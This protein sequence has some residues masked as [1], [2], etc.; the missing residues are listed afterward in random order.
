MSKW[1]KLRNPFAEKV[2]YVNPSYKTSLETSISSASGK[3]KDTLES[4]RDIPSAYWLD[5]K[6]KIK[7]GSTNTMEGILE[8]AANKPVPELVL[9]IVYDLPNRDCHAKAS[10]GEICCSYKSDGRCD[11]TD[12]SDKF[13]SAGLKEYEEEY[14]DQIAEVLRKYS[15]RVPV[16]LVI[17]PDSL[18]N[19]STN[20]GDP[21]CGNSATKSAYEEGVSYAVKALATADPY[22]AIYLD[23]GHGGW[24]GWKDN[25]KDFVK[26]IKGLKVSSHIRGFA[27]N[28]AGY[29][30]VGEICD[31]YDFCLGGNNNDHPCCADPCDLIGQWNPSNNELNYAL[32]LRK[33]MS[34]GIQGF[35]PHMIIDTGRNGAAGMRSECKNWCNIRGAGVG[36]VATIATANPEVVDAYFWLKTPGESDGCTQVLPD[37]S[38]C[39]RFDTDCASVDSIGSRN[40][41]PRAPEAGQWF[42]F[43][44]KQLAE[45][46]QLG[47][48]S[49]T[50][51]PGS[52]S[53]STTSSSTAPASTTLVTSTGSMLVG[54]PFAEKVFYVNPSYKTSLETSIGSASGKIK[55]TLESMRDIPS[56]Y[57]LDNKGKIKG[58]STNTMEGILEDAANK[59]VPE[60]VLFIVYD[61]PNR[62]CHAKASNGEICCSYKSDGRCDYTD[63]SDKFCS[64]GLKEYEEEY[65]DQ[66]AE[67]LRKYSGRVPVVLVIEPDSLPNLSTNQGDP[68]CGNSATKSAYEEGVSYAVKALATADPYAAI[69]LDAGHGGWLGWKDNMKDFVKTIKGLKVSS[70]IRGFAS[71]V[72]GYQHVGEICDTYDFCL[73]GNNNDHPCCA[74]PCDLIGQWNPSNNELNY[75][76]HLRKAMSEGIQGFMPHMII[77]TGRNGAAGMRSECKN[78]CNIRGAGVGHVATIA[79]ANPEVVD[80]YFWLKTPGESDGCTQ[81]LPDGSSCPRFDTDCASVDS[82][83]SRNDE[84]RAPEAGQWFD[85]QIKQLAENAQLGMTSETT[86]PGSTSLSTTSSSTAPASTTLVTSTGSM[87]VGNPFAE[88]VFYVNPSY[89]TSLETSIGSASGKIKDTLESMRDIP[90]AYWLDNKGKIKGGSTNTMEGILEDAA[91]K[92]VPELVLF[93]V[94]DLPNRDCHAKASN[95]EICCSYKSDGRCDYTD[96]SDKFC[97]AGLKEYEEEYI[98]QIAEVLRK[99]SGRVPVV[100]VIEPDSLPNLSTNQ[101]DPR[102]GNSATKSAYEEGVSY[103]V[104][105]LATADP[106]A[107]IYLDAGHGGWLGWKDN[108]KDF[109][110]TIKGLK[111]SSHIRGFASNVAGYQH[112]GEICDT[113]DFCLG[114]NNNDHPCCADPC[115]LIG[116][117][118]PSNNELNYALHLRK[119]MSEGI[120]G[121]MPHMI[122]DTGRN[123]AAGMRSECKNWCNIRGAGVGHVATIAT[124]NP[125]VVDAYFWLKTPGESDGCTQVLPDGS[126]CPRFDTDCASVDSIGSRNDEP[127]AP[128]AGQWFDFQIKQ[129]AE[130]ARLQ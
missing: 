36:H 94:Y 105:A 18:P 116:Q 121:F 52:T 40:D 91:N 107:A 8:D 82:I 4:M 11:Y 21:R 130:N 66:I 86:V 14:I 47:M 48:T 80:A 24:L 20:Q 37:G 111:V 97:S 51:V 57:W 10:N 68:R 79:T 34:E 7:G 117:W 30:H 43:Q 54:N 67:V 22:A 83:G 120:Q 46:A 84:P 28:V 109:V 31:T 33:A 99:Y 81:V 59:P 41:E 12:V 76:L 58:G 13:C 127:R 95:G 19:L 125:E 88:K 90:S 45:N 38:S 87:L 35:M 115:D 61:L 98:D 64:A 55:D 113:Y 16:V 129:L 6:G 89:K 60:L 93:I 122:I 102:C 44:I 110:K 3:I 23:A 56:A 17:E 114:G 53:L 49:E 74:D 73:G 72:A 118:N 42:D 39:P 9:F 32:H 108:M 106:Y 119:A 126:S 78:W 85:F 63:V 123:G 100:L 25:M 65:I 29:Q 112:V 15:G 70:H 96:V 75:A 50:T 62:D 124:A 5:N 69:Y 101:G 71:N 2:F 128:E 27:S 103:A 1:Q 26:T 77:D 104:K 92:P